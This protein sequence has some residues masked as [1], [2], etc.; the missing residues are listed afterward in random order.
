[1]KKY[2]EGKQLKSNSKSSRSFFK[3]KTTAYLLYNGLA[4]LC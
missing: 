4:S 1:V 2:R 3:L